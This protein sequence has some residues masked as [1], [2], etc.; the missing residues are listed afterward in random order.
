[1][2]QHV[3]AFPGAPATY[4]QVAQQNWHQYQEDDPEEEGNWWE[5]Y[6]LLTLF[7]ME[8][9]IITQFS[10]GSHGHHL[11]NGTSRVGEGS[12]LEDRRKYLYQLLCR[13]CMQGCNLRGL[14]VLF[15]C[16]VHMTSNSCD[17]ISF[18]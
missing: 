10:S 18:S 15:A 2:Q 14:K 5:G 11:H 6:L 8:N 7:L 17:I 3:A 12:T 16:S 9:D 1:M 4:K 13:L